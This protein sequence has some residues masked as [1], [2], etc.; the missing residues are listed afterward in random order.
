MSEKIC[1]KYATNESDYEG[2][3]SLYDYYI[4]KS[5]YDYYKQQ[6]DWKDWNVWMTEE[7]KTKKK[8]DNA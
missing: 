3:E 4:K 1:R 2:W 7:L 5:L 8:R 6:N